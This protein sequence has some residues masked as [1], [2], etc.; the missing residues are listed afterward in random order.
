MLVGFCLFYLWEIARGESNDAGRAVGSTLLIAVLG[1]A[2]GFLARAW[3]RG[4]GWPNTPTIVWNVLLL[5]IAWTVLTGGQP[6]VGVLVGVVAVVGIIAAA[7]AGD[8][9]VKT[10]AS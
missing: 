2:L 1:A 10:G 3:V 9:A 6:V 8:P 4:A 5:P 7:R